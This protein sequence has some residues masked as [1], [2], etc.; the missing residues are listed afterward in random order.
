LALILEKRALMFWKSHDFQPIWLSGAISELKMTAI[1]TY[2]EAK[3]GLFW[4][5][6]REGFDQDRIIDTG[7][8]R[9]SQKIP[10]ISPIRPPFPCSGRLFGTNSRKTCTNVLEI[11][12]F[13]ANLAI[14]DY[15]ED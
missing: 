1:S 13:S 4:L 3:P 10:L 15:I 7:L 5:G 11:P 8:K 14:W 2:W 12:R 9:P 6:Y